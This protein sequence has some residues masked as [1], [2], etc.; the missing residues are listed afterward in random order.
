[1]P[2]KH[3]MRKLFLTVCL[4]LALLSAF[5]AHIK[6]G[7]FTYEYLG[8]G[9]NNP[10]YLRYKITLTI[11][12]VCNPST[13]QLTDPI[14]I[15]IFQ[16][17]TSTQYANPSVNITNQYPLVKKFDEPCI[18]GN[19]AV[20]YYQIVEY[21]L[22]NYE[23][24]VNAAGYTLSYQRCCR[25]ANMENVQN[26]GSVGNTWSIMIPG[27][28]SSVPNA[29]KNS[30][31]NFLVND[32]AVV[33]GGNYFEYPFSAT[34]KDGDVLTYTLCDAFT[35]G[36]VAIAAPNPADP[37]PYTIL[38]YTPPYFGAQP[39]GSRV[40]INPTTGLINGIAPVPNTA[41]GEF[42]VTVCITETRA[43]QV[44]EVVR[45]E[46]HIQVKDCTPV[47]ARLAPKGVTCNGFNV[48]FANAAA[49]NTAGINYVWDFGDAASGTN[50]TSALVNPSHVYTDTG[51]Y[52]VKL[53]VSV[54][55][56]CSSTD[57]LVV[58]VYPGFFPGFKA[59]AP[60]CKGAP[61][62]FVD[63]TK[64]NYG[65]P[66][67]WRWNFGNTV[68]TNDT[69]LAQNPTYIYP[70]SG[71]YKVQLIAGNT[72]GCI[73]TVS[74]TIQI[75]PAPVIKLI[76]HDTLICVI[77]TLQLNANNTG[78]FSW[79][80]NY[81]ISST[82][83]ANPLVSPD[84]PTI[85][86]V[87]LTDAFGCVNK[88]SVF[89]NVKAVVTIDAGN[90][91]TIC[92][93][94]GMFMNT[95][96]D[97]LKYVWTP[98]TY[99]SSDTARRPFAN[100]LVSSITYKVVGSIGKCNAT[101]DITITTLPYPKAYAGNDTTVCYGF[102]VP[103][104]ASGGVGYL[105]TPA[106]FLN[107]ANIANPVAVNPT[108]TTQYIVAVTDVVGCPKPA[109]D[110]VLVNVEA[111]VL[112]N[113][114]PAD[115]TVVLGEPLQLNGS[116][117]TIYLWQPA[118]WLSNPSIAN[119]VS[120]PQNDITYKLLVSNATGCQQS[121]TIRIKVY[122]VPASFYVPTGFTPN[123]DNHND[124]LR[125]ILLGMRS[126]NY[127]RVYNRWGN[128]VFSTSQ[129]G[130]GWDGTYKGNLQDPGTYIWMAS[131]ITYLGE[132]IVRKGYAVLIR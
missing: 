78:S 31:P 113:A 53:T 47:L 67:G 27:T 130:L 49:N 55:G 95:T 76:T 18:S 119:P 98:A 90:D 115:T 97:A 40:T 117:G 52:K 28:N 108:A 126:L 85:Y 58:K 41:G 121:D 112:A 81:N 84:V 21:V 93:T 105:W 29:N 91:T 10:A 120:L 8:Q 22:N 83:I 132:T 66:T 32:T 4:S 101:S 124:V 123:N 116:G 92:K 12:M 44:V 43:G 35:G 7:F 110:T 131:G 70:D 33:C 45:K 89:V 5:S 34:D 74:Q 87:T 13:G 127:F 16:G 68:A 94:D 125:P 6:G 39:M 64:T 122:R 103:L 72:F 111:K 88:D 57:S 80:P 42:V 118:T 96:S 114:G 82:S 37:P 54:S 109:F 86:L 51:V 69:S 71:S 100:P 46:L 23:L 65:S 99:L 107:N 61:V 59:N 62:Q 56:L 60:L 26:S 17:N 11:Y 19:Q 3:F 73:D 25:I 38:N 1:M 104:M 128:V 15:T 75:S 79:S 77:D 102:N 24:P 63:T 2:I 129:K 9:I 20:C 48:N 36:S 14:N 106:T 30:S 50:N